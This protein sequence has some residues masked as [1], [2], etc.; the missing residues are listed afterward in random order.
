M[1]IHKLHSNINPL[2]FETGVLYV[3]LVFKNGPPR[4]MIITLVQTAGPKRLV[5][6][7]IPC[8]A[9]LSKTNILIS[10]GWFNSQ[11][12]TNR[13]ASDE[14]WPNIAHEQNT[15]VTLTGY[16]IVT[17]FISHTLSD[18]K[19]RCLNTIRISTRRMDIVQATPGC[20]FCLSPH[21]LTM[22]NNLMPPLK[23]THTY[24]YPCPT[25]KLLTLSLIPPYLYIYSI[26]S[27]RSGT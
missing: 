1:F 11:E 20:T 13:R 15:V 14:W 22:N 18:G 4:W 3:G 17:M 19:W 25:E 23:T 10:L 16:N 6:Y 9:Q 21:Q 24:I 26:P 12:T 5:C 27:F 2:V 8:K 7:K